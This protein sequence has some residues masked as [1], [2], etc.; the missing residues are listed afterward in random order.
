MSKMDPRALRSAF[1]S[2]MSGVTVVTA[3]DSDG[4][5]VGFTANSFSSVSMDPPLLLVCPGKFL[6]SY[7]VFA[8]CTHFAIN[9][10]AEGQEEISNTFAS[11][12]GDRCAQVHHL[13]N[14]HGVPLI[15]G[16]IAQFSCSTHQSIE[17]GDHSILIGHVEA[18]THEAIPGLGYV[19]GQY[20]SL[21]LERAALESSWGT[22]I[23]GAIIQEAGHVFLESTPNGHR[24]PQITCTDRGRL[25]HSLRQDLSTRGIPVQ[26]GQAYSAFDDQQSSLHHAYFLASG[27]AVSQLGPLQ[28]VPICDLATLTYTT[29]AIAQMMT[30][31]ALETR[32]GNFALYLGDALHGDVHTL[33]ERT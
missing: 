16:A 24:P 28:A 10:L 7:E 8:N 19:G 15:R 25:R 18:Y 23:C 30:R 1:G 22:V 20:F 11:F 29:P 27:T 26:L 6:S 14:L 12:K 5:P 13:P 17:A 2:F 33:T 32:T 21:G 31:F 4:Q 3:L 9:V